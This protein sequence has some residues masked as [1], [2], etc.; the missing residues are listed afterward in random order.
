M[1]FNLI[2]AVLCGI[3]LSVSIVC[4]APWFYYIG[5][6]FI[7]VVTVLF[8]FSKPKMF[9]ICLLLFRAAIDPFLINVRF[10]VAGIDLGLGGSLSILLVGAATI[11][12]M[13]HPNAK[14]AFQPVS[15]AWAIFCLI[16]IMA[17][18]FSYHR[19]DAIK[20]E[21]RYLSVFSVMLLSMMFADSEKSIGEMLG[22]ILWSGALTVI[23]GVG[24]FVLKHPANG[25]FAATLGHPNIL[26]FYLLILLGLLFSGAA[27]DM[28][29]WK[30]STFLVIFF[31][32]LI[33]T[34][35]RSGWLAF[36]IMTFFY[37]IFYN[38]KFLLP[39]LALVVLIG[40]TPIIKEHLN[41]A[42]VI[43][44]SGIQV[45]SNGAL[46]WRLEKWAYLWDAFLQR[47][48]TGYGVSSA[49]EFGNDHLAA[50]NDYLRYLLE[51]GVFGMIFAFLPYFLVLQKAFSD[52][53]KKTSELQKRLAIFVT[54][55]VPAFLI[56]S[57]SENLAAYIVI[58]WYLWA[59]LGTYLALNT[60]LVPKK[61]QS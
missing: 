41:N 38:R 59:I 61:V 51:S 57:F 32:A 5:F 2:V 24:Y 54:I 37:S 34:K 53:R 39:G 27:K 15:T 31:L 14:K 56:M 10:S 29:K 43:T 55:F 23:I 7:V 50:H 33:F 47:P 52:L 26:S 35:T 28:S 4:G 21:L 3:A 17:I 16:N 44:S 60:S 6:G 30:H 1:K 45:N 19:A 48:F 49:G 36:V 18:L 25:R 12:L 11:L 22:A 58:H 40:F 13:T 46:G 8:A 20:A 42:F 9:L